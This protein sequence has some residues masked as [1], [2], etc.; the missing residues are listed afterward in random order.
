MHDWSQLDLN[1][2][3]CIAVRLQERCVCVRPVAAI[4]VIDY[5]THQTDLVLS[6]VRP[7]GA[8]VLAAGSNVFRRPGSNRLVVLQCTP[9]LPGLPGPVF[10]TACPFDVLRPD[11]T[12]GW[13]PRLSGDSPAG[14]L[15]VP[16]FHRSRRRRSSGA[17]LLWPTVLTR[18]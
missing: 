8:V 7:V 9:L 4:G 10:L 2:P 13:Q 15:C 17:R 3:S 12:T 1:F 5:Q 18:H 14:Y 11:C 16:Q 6:Y